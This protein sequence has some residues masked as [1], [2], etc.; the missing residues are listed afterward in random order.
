MNGKQAI[1]ERF[2]E[3]LAEQYTVMVMPHSQRKPVRF[4]IRVWA[5]WAVL[6]TA[7][8]VIG[9]SFFLMGFLPERHRAQAERAAREQLT[10]E[11]A[12]LE[13]SQELLSVEKEQAELE[14]EALRAELEALQEE[15]DASEES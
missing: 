10:Q 15:Q 4:K 13:R 7:V 8:L 2:K 6:L 12:A 1:G 14:L 11:K 5:V 9:T 3:H